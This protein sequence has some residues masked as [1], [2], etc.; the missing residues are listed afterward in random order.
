MRTREW[1]DS[2]EG[3]VF[4]NRVIMV[5]LGLF[6]IG[7]AIAG[8]IMTLK[9]PLI[10]VEGGYII[11]TVYAYAGVVIILS[12]NRSPRFII[13]LAGVTFAVMNMIQQAAILTLGDVPAAWLFITMDFVMIMSCIL[14][15]L[16]DRYSALRILG[17]AAIQLVATYSAQ[18]SDVLEITYHMYGYTTFWWMIVECLFLIT[19][20][21]LLLRPGIRD[22]SV[23]SRIRRGIEIVDS[24]M[25]SA[26][27]AYIDA[28]CKDALT[29]KDRSEW[30]AN[31]GDG[32]IE[33]E[34]TT[35]V[36]DGRKVLRLISY[37]W[38][39]EDE[40]RFTVLPDLKSRTYGRGFVLRAHSVEERDGIS[41]LRLYGDEGFFLKILLL[42]SAEVEQAGSEEH[43]EDVDPIV[44]VGDKIMTG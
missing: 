23:K 29:G 9:E 22:D 20:M 36:H 3:I 35:E 31:E 5:V 39:G 7:M 4:V 38:K 27:S 17:I 6:M 32:P 40:V 24:M 8:V 12:T 13:F 14:C 43:P 19:Y 28:K 41:Y 11:M 10:D 30:A 37:R 26:P 16:G 34:Y 42:D 25:I 1:W 44:Y 15:L 33:S 2:P 21:F 18:M